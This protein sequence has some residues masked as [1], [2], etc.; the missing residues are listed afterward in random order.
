MGLGG[1]SRDPALSGWAERV[2]DSLAAV[3]R[4]CPEIP[5]TLRLV[6]AVPIA[7]AY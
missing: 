5:R 4:E 2:K 7:V 6:D 1:T 3:P